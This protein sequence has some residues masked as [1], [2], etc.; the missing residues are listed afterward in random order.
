MF[1]EDM[2]VNQVLDN[3]RGYLKENN[4]SVTDLYGKVTFTRFPI[5]LPVK[6]IFKVRGGTEAR[7]IDLT[8]ITHQFQNIRKAGNWPKSMLRYENLEERIAAFLLK[9]QDIDEDLY[10]DSD[11]FFI[12]EPVDDF[13]GTKI[14]HELYNT[15][16]NFNEKEP[17][18][19]TN[20]LHPIS[21]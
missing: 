2:S 5:I 18:V 14:L 15:G 21:F 1:H 9:H 10:W 8:E 4:L 12:I 3:Y 6:D 7:Y 20:Q 19:L 11:T 17:W 13:W 16:E